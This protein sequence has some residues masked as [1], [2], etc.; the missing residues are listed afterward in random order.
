MIDLS[1][2]LRQRCGTEELFILNDQGLG[3]RKK[4]AS[5]DSTRDY[6]VFQDIAAMTLMTD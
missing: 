6:P 5:D 2:R 4:T 1:K 3:P